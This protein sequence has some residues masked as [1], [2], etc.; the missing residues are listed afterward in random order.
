MLLDG[1]TSPNVLKDYEYYMGT[2]YVKESDAYAGVKS[3]LN[4]YIDTNKK[5]GVPVTPETIWG[6][7]DSSGL[8]DPEK[9][10][11]ATELGL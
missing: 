6:M 3:D 4:R 7:I 10:K 8:S 2:P 1:N 11:L 9:I 5:N